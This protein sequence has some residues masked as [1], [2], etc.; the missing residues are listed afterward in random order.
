MT[1][2]IAVR[3]FRAGDRW[4]WWAFWYLPVLFAW[5]MFTTWAVG[6]FLALFVLAV[7]RLLVSRSRFFPPG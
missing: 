6:L 3:W 1:G 7:G 2:V 5:F 4:S